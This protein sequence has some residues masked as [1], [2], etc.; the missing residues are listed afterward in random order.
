MISRLREP[1]LRLFYPQV[2]CLGC[3]EPRELDPDS[4]LCDRCVAVL[5]DL[6]LGS[7]RCPHCLSPRR[8]DQPCRYCLE[9]GMQH[10]SAAY[11]PFHYHGPVQRLV[12]RLKFQGIFLAAKPL[13]EGMLS[14]LDGSSFDA[15][16]PVPLHPK[17]QRERGF[18]QAALL[19]EAVAKE[20]HVPILHAIQRIRDSRRQSSLPHHKRHKN[21]NGVFAA[22]RDVTGM[23]L[24]LV[25]D[26]RTT[27]STAR[28]C[29]Q[30]LIQAGASEVSLL[31]AAVAPA[32]PSEKSSSGG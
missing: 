30:V 16:V 3:D 29:A 15:L 21:V 19:A 28:A 4:P 7:G 14:A 8:H 6:R 32:Y 10:L 31:T 20:R 18:N 23:K 12:T 25:D 26:V 17:R 22:V 9:Q 11:A 13:A 2:R 27:G 24:L 5:A 1:L